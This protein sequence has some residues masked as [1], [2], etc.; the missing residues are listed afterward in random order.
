M[1]Q[2]GVAYDFIFVNIC[3]GDLHNSFARVKCK[4]YGN[5]Q[6]EELFFNRRF[7]VVWCGAPEPYPVRFI[8]P[9]IPARSMGYL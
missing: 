6:Q 5:E 8:R 2:L 7:C 4:D 9:Q 3:R 1:R